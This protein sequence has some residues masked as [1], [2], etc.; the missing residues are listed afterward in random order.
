MAE[1]GTKFGAILKNGIIA[2]HASV[3]NEVSNTVQGVIA[4]K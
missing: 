2:L 1:L 4:K 3:W